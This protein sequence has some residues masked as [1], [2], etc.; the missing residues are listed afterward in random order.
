M[1]SY[2]KR[3]LD[4][5]QENIAIITTTNDYAKLFESMQ[6]ATAQLQ[7]LVVSRFSV[8]HD[9]ESWFCDSDD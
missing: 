4:D 5:L 6:C 1:N 7:R 8:L 3:V 2:E 9:D